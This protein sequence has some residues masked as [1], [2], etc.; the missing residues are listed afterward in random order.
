MSAP[1]RKSRIVL[2]RR[3]ALCTLA[4]ALTFAGC[5]NDPPSEGAAP[6][7]ETPGPRTEGSFEFAVIGDF[8][9]GSEDE[10][11]VAAAVHEWVTDHSADA[12]VTTG[13][14]IYPS[15]ESE[16]FHEAW[17]E[18]YGWV[19]A[20]DLPVIASLGNH[21]IEADGGAAVME[22]LGMPDRWYS[23]VIGDAEIF[24]LDA[25]DPG[26]AEQM[27]WLEGALGSS[28][29]IWKVVVFHQP[30]YSCSR[31]DGTPAV[32]ADWVPLFENE[33]VD[34]V[35]NGHDHAY[36]RFAPEGGPMYV[37][38]GGAGN[39]LYGL[40]ECPDGYPVRVASD[41]DSHHFV[42]VSG[43][44]GGI[45]VKAITSDDLVLDEFTLNK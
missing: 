27:D 5:V 33:G 43:T 14:N 20:E 17:E 38:T 42:A 1:A 15:G 40:D 36:Q 24:V 16:D 9:V 32:Q 44:L 11:E 12:L 3:M 25:N 2:P 8:G 37:V 19:G 23:E 10:S 18:P 31:H 22:L 28:E 6:L 7:A 21:D 45:N 29:A 13:D 35:L 41:D 26:S 34:L 30:A 4:L 39:V